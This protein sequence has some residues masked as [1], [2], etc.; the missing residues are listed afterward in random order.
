MYYF[1]SLALVVSG[2]AITASHAAEPE[3]PAAKACEILVWQSKDYVSE[4]PSPYAAYGLIGA[5]AQSA[6]DSRYPVGSTESQMENELRKEIIEPIV[7]ALPWNSFIQADTY[8]ISF[9]D[10]AIT[11]DGI[12]ALRSA[13]QRRSP[14]TAPCYFELYIDRQTFL[15]GMVQ[16]NLMSEFTIRIFSGETFRSVNGKS[17]KKVKGFPAKD[18]ATVDAA[19]AS[20][21][22]AFVDNL[23]SFVANKLTKG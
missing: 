19:S 8:R 16:S 23:N 21:R 9:V 15:G 5:I 1:R 18:A 13:K 17:F 22:A 6:H 4:A 20:F 2:L 11:R 14:S 12:K 7:K 3:T 10:E